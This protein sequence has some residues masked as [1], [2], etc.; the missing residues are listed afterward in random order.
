M[1]AYYPPRRMSL[2][3]VGRRSPP[4]TGYIPGQGPMSR[5]QGRPQ[6]WGKGMSYPSESGRGY[7]G[8]GG[9]MGGGPQF[10]GP[11]GATVGYSP[12]MGPM[13]RGGYSGP[14]GGGPRMP[15]DSFDP[16]EKRMGAGAPRN[17]QMGPQGQPPNRYTMPVVRPGEE[18]GGGGP[19]DS[20]Y[21][22][23]WNQLEAYDPFTRGDVRNDPGWSPGLFGGEDYQR[24]DRGEF[25]KDPGYFGGGRRDWGPRDYDR[26]PGR[27]DPSQ[28]DPYADFERSIYQSDPTRTE[29]QPF[30][31]TADKG[32]QF[33]IAEAQKAVERS[34]A[35][36]GNALSPAAMMELQDRTSSI[37][38][39]EADRAYGRWSNDRGFEQGENER[40]FQGGRQ[41]LADA[42]GRYGENRGFD[43]SERGRRFG[44]GQQAIAGAHGRFASDRGYGLESEGMRQGAIAGAAGRS[45]RGRDWRTSERRDLK[46]RFTGQVRD[47][48]NRR[49]DEMR[50][51][52]GVRGRAF[53]EN[54]RDTNQQFENQLRG[55]EAQWNRHMGIAD[56]G[57]RYFGGMAGAASDYGGGAQEAYGGIGNAQA[58][59]RVGSAN[60]WNQG[61]TD[62]GQGFAD[63]Y[64][65]RRD[66]RDDPYGYRGGRNGGWDEWD[67]NNSRW[68]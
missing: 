35:A 37:A 47:A 39:D 3:Q 21:G 52:E 11:G 19:D 23:G 31:I 36:R 33:R 5:G 32:Y 17:N 48:S 16:M 59:G 24:F 68:G 56:L 38:G 18:Q 14:T 63:Y 40:M 26:D 15:D 42:F 12:G 54:F 44:Q 62:A 20:L 13:G 66:P 61:L 28:E 46:D 9:P 7:G 43:Q 67:E 34:A 29:T 49:M 6:P 4:G 10:G 8:Y 50:Y 45:E 57:A 55:D 25:Q 65:G 27:Y 64:A 53:D 51:R 22:E 41:T 58:G 30:D 2:G 60:A 1:G